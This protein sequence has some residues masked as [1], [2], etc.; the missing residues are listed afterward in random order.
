MRSAELRIAAAAALVALSAC[1]VSPQ[2]VQPALVTR[3][4]GGPPIPASGPCPASTSDW[5]IA[6]HAGP[7]IDDRPMFTVTG[8]IRVKDRQWAELRD[9]YPTVQLAAPLLLVR[10]N[11]RT[12][13]TATP[14]GERV[15]ALTHSQPVSSEP[16]TV[17][18]RC[19]SQVV[20][21]FEGVRW[22]G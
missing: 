21:R 4:S 17:L 1:A 15:V 3:T 11:V 5:R 20:A 18:V 22:A 12:S 6:V 13:P 16:A 7:G 8:R 10:L 19:G 9:E 2:P 14:A